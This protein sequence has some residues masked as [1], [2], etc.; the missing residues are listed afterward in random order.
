[1]ADRPAVGFGGEEGKR[2]VALAAVREHFRPEFFNRVDHVVPF[3][4]LDRESVL[5]IVDL[6]LEKARGRTG[7]VRRSLRLSATPGA[8]ARLAELGFDV[9]RGA[10]PLKRVIEEQVI[11]PI[12]AR[13]AADAGYRD[14]EIVIREEGGAIAVG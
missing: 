14:R 12:A 7:L 13:M 2:G 5:R 6:E 3:G 4:A 10:R 1:V 8:R 11:T 9:R